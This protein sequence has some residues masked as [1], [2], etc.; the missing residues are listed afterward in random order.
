MANRVRLVGMKSCTMLVV[1]DGV[2]VSAIL[3]VLAGEQVVAAVVYEAAD[4]GA[5]ME[6]A[7]M[8]RTAIVTEGFEVAA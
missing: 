2:V 1:V 4:A 3:L 8:R 5:R 7:E 6:A